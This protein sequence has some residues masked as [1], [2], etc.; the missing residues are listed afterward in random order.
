MPMPAYP[1]ACDPFLL[2]F[3]NMGFETL[4]QTCHVTHCHF[5]TLFL[6]NG[7]NFYLYLANRNHLTK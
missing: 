2:M 7:I 5:M 4:V 1:A 3:K 6:G